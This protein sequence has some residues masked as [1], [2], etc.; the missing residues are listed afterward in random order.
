MSSAEV[1]V[2]EYD[3]YINVEQLSEYVDR[4]YQ[5]VTHSVSPNW[6]GNQNDYHYYT[7]VREPNKGQ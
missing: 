6:D 4:G 3:D 1:I 2:L 7:L 5:I